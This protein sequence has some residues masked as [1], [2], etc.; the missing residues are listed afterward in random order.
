ML[1]AFKLLC[2]QSVSGEKVDIFGDVSVGHCEKKIS[3]DRASN[4]EW[5]HPILS[6]NQKGLFAVL[7]LHRY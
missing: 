7:F 5:S 1:G 4:S 6:G 2:I 3:Y